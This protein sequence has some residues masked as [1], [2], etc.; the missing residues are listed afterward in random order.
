MKLTRFPRPG[1]GKGEVY[2]VGETVGVRRRKRKWGMLTFGMMEV[3][4]LRWKKRGPT[5]TMITAA[6]CR[7]SAADPARC[8]PVFRRREALWRPALGEC[9]ADHWVGHTTESS[10]PIL[11]ESEVCMSCRP[12]STVTSSRVLSLFNSLWNV[13]RRCHHVV[14]ITTEMTSQSM[15]RESVS[16]YNVSK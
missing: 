16:G 13:T 11:S 5:T 3:P 9:R 6:W 8:R 10:W 4:R 14:T 12:L 15:S 2:G 1:D 7:R